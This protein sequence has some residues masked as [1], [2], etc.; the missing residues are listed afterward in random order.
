[1]VI[2]LFLHLG[3]MCWQTWCILRLLLRALWQLPN[4]ISTIFAFNSTIQQQTGH[5]TFYTWFTMSSF[6]S[7]AGCSLHTLSPPTIHNHSSTCDATQT[8]WTERD[9]VCLSHTACS[10]S[11][12]F[13]LPILP[14]TGTILGDPI[15]DIENLHTLHCPL[16]PTTCYSNGI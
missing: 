2:S 14:I 16:G 13:P 4:K 7:V 10:N 11:T 6:S 8:P 9:I 5:T 1:V 15:P 3:T 12:A